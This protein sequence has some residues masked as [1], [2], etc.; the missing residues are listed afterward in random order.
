MQSRNLHTD[1]DLVSALNDGDVNAFEMIYRKYVGEL[2]RYARWNIST[3]EDCEELIQDVFESVWA[4]HK[5]L[6]PDTLRSY[7]LS[8]VKYKV[9]RYFQHSRVK[10]K[11]IDHYRAFEAVYDNVGEEAVDPVAMQ[12]RIEKSLQA[13]PERCQA[14]FRL[15]LHENLSNGDIAERMNITKKTVE[16][17][18]FQA[19]KHLRASYHD[20]FKTG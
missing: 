14:A 16:V 18:M 4:R 19:F 15:R 6:K 13:L 2:Y 1:A 9:I 20:L 5:T 12:A 8:M 11:Y 10:K 17:Y 7:L 3:K